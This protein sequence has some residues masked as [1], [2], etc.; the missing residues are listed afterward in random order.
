[1]TAGEP[2]G[3][4]FAPAPR[5]GLVLGERYRL[6]RRLGMGG[7]G[8]VYEAVHLEIPRRFA[9]KLLRAEYAEDAQMQRRFRT[10]ARAAASLTSDHIVQ[11]V[12]FDR[13]DDGSPYLVMEMLEGCDLRRAMNE[14]GPL[15]TDEAVEIV[16]QACEGARIAHAQSIVHRDLK[17]ENLYLA[18][19]GGHHT[20]KVLDFG[21]AKLR[22]H[23]SSTASGK[24][25]GTPAYMSPEQARGSAQ[26]DARTDVYALGVILYEAL[27]AHLPHPG[28]GPHEIISHLLFSEPDPL[29]RWNPEL[30]GALC[31]A[32]HKTLQREPS[33]RYQSAAELRDALVALRGARAPL[34]ERQGALS[35]RPMDGTLLL[36]SAGDALTPSSAGDAPSLRATGDAHETLP[37][38]DSE[39][40]FEARPH[41]A[42]PRAP[43]NQDSGTPHAR[44]RL[45]LGLLAGAALVGAIARWQ[46][47][48]QPAPSETQPPSASGSA[49]SAPVALSAPPHAPR[50]A[51][52]PAVEAVAVAPVALVA[53]DAATP[54]IAARPALSVRRAVAAHP[55]PG[56]ST[57]AASEA[58]PTVSAQDAGAEPTTFEVKRGKHT[59]VFRRD[60]PLRR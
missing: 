18:R 56:V 53:I 42:P 55:A 19:R 44:Q 31:A 57:H 20:V 8:E 40:R 51:P 4:S 24:L 17:P 48:P 13:A 32:V 6:G 47:H 27:S 26:V 22:A 36:R 52:V 21:I 16:I 29:A 10:E 43:R 12:D 28:E 3:K 25:L 39:V 60:N 11:V 1:M 33:A 5:T 49:T 7:M 58:E 23:G 59:I 45:A 9:I 35:L 38:R 46:T 34:P 30:P 15:A 50:S 54:P 41:A 2:P 14:H 37:A